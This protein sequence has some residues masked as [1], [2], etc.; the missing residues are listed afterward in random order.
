MDAVNDAVARGD[1]ATV[2]QLHAAG[3][4]WSCWMS[5]RA[6]EHGH[7][8]TLQWLRAHG[9]PWDKAACLAGYLPDDMRAWILSGAGDHGCLTKSAAPRARANKSL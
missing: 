4:K 8:D 6:A 3:A 2:Q 5:T 9:C 1:L 7:L